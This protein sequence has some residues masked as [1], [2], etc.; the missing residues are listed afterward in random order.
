[1]IAIILILFSSIFQA[2]AEDDLCTYF[3]NCGSGSQS[4]TSKSQPSSGSSAN[5]NPSN[6]SNIKGLGV[7]TLYQ[8][9]NSLGF[10]LVTG[11]GNVGGALIT[12]TSENSFF[13]NRAI[14]IDDVYAQRRNEKKRYKTKKLNVALGAKILKGKNYA[15]DLGVS[16]KRN[17]DVK[18][19]NPGVGFSARLGFLNFGAYVY[20]DDTKLD[21]G[22]YYDPY[23]QMPYSVRFGSSTYTETFTATTLSV[24]TQIGNLSL[25]AGMIKTKYKFYQNE[26]S[27]TIYSSAYNYK[28][29]LFNLAYRKESSDNLKEDKGFLTFERDKRDYYAGVQYLWNKHVNTGIAYN[30]FLVHDI[31]F[32]LILFL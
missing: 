32:T 26:T 28:K 5:F 17:P 25:D 10:N 22:N 1:M 13:G 27:V 4:S 29:F 3:K 9:N 31:S 11:T 18:K 2:S 7:E 24:G 6:I 8:P 21:L 23:S 12:P 15:F 20:K 30:N 14:E 19:I 16:L